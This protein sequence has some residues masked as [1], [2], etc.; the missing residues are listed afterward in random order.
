PGIRR[1]PA[2]VCWRPRVRARV[3]PPRLVQRLRT[4]PRGGGPPPGQSFAGA[5]GEPRGAGSHPP[6]VPV[7]LPCGARWRRLSMGTGS[8]GVLTAC[9]VQGIV[10]FATCSTKCLVLAI[11]A[12]AALA[13]SLP[14][15]AAVK[16]IVLV[17][18]AF[19]DGSGWKPVADIL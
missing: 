4:R 5:G 16:T 11:I 6:V 19:A 15:H 12:G 17:H 7:R 18:G 2:D 10:M 14:A 8:L 3:R 13:T 9:G 1:R